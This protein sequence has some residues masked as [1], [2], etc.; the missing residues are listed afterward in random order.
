MIQVEDNLSQAE[1]KIIEIIRQDNEIN[2]R[3]FIK[4]N[5]DPKILKAGLEEA[6]KCQNKTIINL[7]IS[8][9][10]AV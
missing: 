8:K 4:S 7:L 6:F 5:N 9:G 10:A 2:L 3:E 1:K